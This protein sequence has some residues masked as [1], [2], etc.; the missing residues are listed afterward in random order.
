[1][2]INEGVLLPKN[3]TK[4]YDITSNYELTKVRTI[5]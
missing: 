1:M 3:Q 2:R 5:P 4:K